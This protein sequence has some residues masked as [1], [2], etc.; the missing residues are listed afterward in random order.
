V[1]RQG[2]YRWRAQGP[3]QRERT[4][5]ELTKLIRQIH[6][7]LSGDPGARRVWAELVVRGYRISPTR[8][9]RLMKAA[10]LHG[11][12]PRAGKKTTIAAQR[13]VDAP[14]LSEQDFAA[15]EPNTRWCG[16]TTYIQTVDGWV[17]AAT[18]TDLPSRKVVGH[19]VADH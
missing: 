6:T 13:P 5:A 11:R 7:E 14:D 18:V 16:D 12:H 19:A 1:Y 4:D 3:C 15:E 2:Y 17:Y 10:S 8:V 9:W